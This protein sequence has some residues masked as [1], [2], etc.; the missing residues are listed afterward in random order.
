MNVIFINGS[1]RK[2]WNTAQLLKAAQKGA[3]SVG[4]ATEY[5]DLYDLT[6]SGCRSCLGCK[7]KG[8]TPCRCIWKDE[9][10]PLL[11]RVCQADRLVLGSPIYFGQPTGGLRSF[12]ERLI[13]PALSYNDYSCLF[14]GHLDVDVFLTMNAPREHYDANYAQSLEE[15]FAPFRFLNGK[16]RLIPICDTLQ[17]KDYSKYDMAGFSEEHKQALHAEQFPQELERAFQLGAGRA[18][19]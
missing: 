2:N 1:P 5:I 17:V 14:K 8:A 18:D 15:Y 11:E 12:L 10:S 19:G 9:L 3:E 13:F 4:A 16:L 7:R 6:F